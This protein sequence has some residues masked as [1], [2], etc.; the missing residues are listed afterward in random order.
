MSG[1]LPA[2]GSPDSR[3][4]D[5]GRMTLGEALYK[6]LGISP[7]QQPAN[8][9]RLLGTSQYEADPEV[10]SAAAD[11]Q[12]GHI[13][14][15][16]AGPHSDLSQQILNQIAAAKVCL[17]N[18][19]KRA[20]YDGA[21]RSGVVPAN[22]AAES[23]AA[24][25]E[26]PAPAP[27]EEPEADPLDYSAAPSFTRTKAAR[28][29]DSADSRLP[30]LTVAFVVPAALLVAAMLIFSDNK[31]PPVADN[32]VAENHV[33]PKPKQKPKPATHAV[34]TPQRKPEPAVPEVSP[35]AP[36]V[37]PATPEVPATSPSPAAPVTP[38]PA[39]QP[40]PTPPVSASPAAPNQPAQPDKP[41]VTAPAPEKPDPATPSSNAITVAADCKE[42]VT[43]V[44]LTAEGVPE[45]EVVMLEI[46][47]LEGFPTAAKMQPSAK[48]NG[49]DGLR[50]ALRSEEPRAEVR[51][52]LVGTGSKRTLKVTPMM[53]IPGME[54]APFTTTRL[55]DAEKTLPDQ[56][57]DMKERIDASVAHCKE[58]DDQLT[59][60]RAQIRPAMNPATAIPLNSQ[61]AAAQADLKR[62]NT[63]Q[64]TLQRKLPPLEHRLE[65]LPALVELVESMAGAKIHFRAFYIVDGKE[66]EL[67][68]TE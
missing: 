5:D 44:S 33:A 38:A 9:Y 34:A 4:H 8:H 54:P 31:A 45:K 18:A 25:A 39:T 63:L 17:L 55:D 53:I 64:K 37:R 58:L 67:Q 16:Q 40:D 26:Q 68:Q 6:W 30:L 10:I 65:R 1:S 61:I 2:A 62:E 20:E 27:Q 51:L 15:Y 36:E 47:Q 66:V 22:P 11:R 42:D 35:A 29:R 43:K 59:A 32:D 13:R 41:P 7:A 60:L 52:Q 28:R 19:A 46:L 12:M 57:K 3:R 56:I 50:I 23:S 49:A 14:T 48:V 24:A 21:L